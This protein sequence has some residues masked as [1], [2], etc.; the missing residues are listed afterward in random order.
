MQN[1][2]SLLSGK[3]ALPI[4]IIDSANLGIGFFWNSKF[5]EPSYH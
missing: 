2:K 4:E 3:N 5:T 1:I